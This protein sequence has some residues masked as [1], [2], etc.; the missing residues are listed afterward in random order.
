MTYDKRYNEK[1]QRYKKLLANH[2]IVPVPVR[3]EKESGF[4]TAIPHHAVYLVSPRVGDAAGFR[5]HSDLWRINL[6]G[7][8]IGGMGDVEDVDYYFDE[9]EDEITHFFFVD[10]LE[11][12]IGLEEFI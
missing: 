9:Y 11:K 2:G 6:E 10:E 5:I 4:S 1:I 12:A 3:W 8:K 7:N